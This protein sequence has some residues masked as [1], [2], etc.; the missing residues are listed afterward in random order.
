MTWFERNK[1]LPA[2]DKRCHVC[3][4]RAWLRRLRRGTAWRKT[5]ETCQREFLVEL[6]EANAAEERELQLDDLRR[7]APNN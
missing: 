6:Q 7:N 1:P 5:C 3:G 4:N 2:G